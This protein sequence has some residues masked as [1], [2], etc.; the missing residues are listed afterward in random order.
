MTGPDRSDEKPQR[1]AI[2]AVDAEDAAVVVEADLVVDEEVV[3]LAGRDHVVV[4]VGPDLDRA[5]ELLGGDRGERGELVALRLLAAEAAAHAPHLD[6]H[7]VATA[8]PAHAPT[9]CCTSLGCWVEE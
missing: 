7:R 8:R 5:A 9:M 3:A 4:A 2:G 1:A 6:G